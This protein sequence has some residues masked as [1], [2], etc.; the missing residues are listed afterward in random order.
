[1]C[2]RDS[3]NI[4]LLLVIMQKLILLLLPLFIQ[5]QDVSI[6]NWKDY[7]SYNSASYIAE[8]TNKIYCVA[9]SGLFYIEKSDNSINRLSKIN[10]LSDVG[11]KQVAYS[12]DL[13]VT[14]ITYENCNIDTVKLR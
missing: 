10:G 13:N 11:V 9:N 5:A 12:K 7:R 6:G 4:V 14:I 3:G 8:T 1:M 2:I